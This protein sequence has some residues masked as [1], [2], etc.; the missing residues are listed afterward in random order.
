M[1][2]FDDD[3]LLSEPGS[4]RGHVHS[5]WPP[6]GRRCG[7]DGAAAAPPGGDVTAMLGALGDGLP[8]GW[9]EG[10]TDSDRDIREGGCASDGGAGGSDRGGNN[11]EDGG[12]G[13]EGGSERDVAS[14]DGSEPAGK[15]DDEREEEVE[16][17]HEGTEDEVDPD[18]LVEADFTLSRCAHLKPT[19]ACAHPMPGSCAPACSTPC[20]HPSGGLAP[21]GA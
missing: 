10:C 4:Q 5:G 21:Q 13:S 12:D 6:S 9:D 18:D 11:D 19:A 20:A 8:P 16:E 15:G 1:D 7:H 3:A 14:Q 2:D 17:H